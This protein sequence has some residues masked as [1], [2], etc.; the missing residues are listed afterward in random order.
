MKTHTVIYNGGAQTLTTVPTGADGEPMLLSAAEATIVDLRY[1][2]DSSDRIIV[3]KAAAT[4]DATTDTTTAAVGLGAASRTRI[5]VGTPANFTEGHS[6]A[7]VDPEGY[8]Q[9]IVV[10]HVDG[11]AVY[12]RNDIRHNFAT[13]ST[14]RGIEVTFTF[15]SSEADDEEAFDLHVVCPYAVDW[16]FTGGDPSQQRELIYMRRNPRPTL[17][18]AHDVEVL[19]IA[20]GKLTKRGNQMEQALE[21]AHRDF[22][23]LVE[24]RKID[25]DTAYFGEHAR[26]WVA[27]MAAAYIR[28]SFGTE[29][30]DEMASMYEHTANGI[31]ASL[32]GFGEVMV[33]KTTDQAAGDISERINWPLT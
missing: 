2:E 10:D 22:Y 30:D 15:P 24:A 19:D 32:G 26:D 14:L 5:E 21:Q 9:E 8:K 6:Y 29:R 1:G 11:S 28:R 4:V 27:R 12:A 3:A 23:R 18:R 20:I 7:L 33:D 25:M 31:F 16:F 13:G 17:A